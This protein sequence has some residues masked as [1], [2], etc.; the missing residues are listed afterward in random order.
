MFSS[1]RRVSRVMLVS[2]AVSFSSAWLIAG[3]TVGSAGV[4]ATEVCAG[5]D[6]GGTV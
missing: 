5:G 1:T 6:A 2:A 4:A 3:E